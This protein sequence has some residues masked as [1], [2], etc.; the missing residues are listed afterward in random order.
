MKEEAAGRSKEGAAAGLGEEEATAGGQ[1]EEGRFS[2]GRG[3]RQSA[4]AV[5]GSGSDFE[6]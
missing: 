4:V 5:G 1:G 3:V 2:R 6:E